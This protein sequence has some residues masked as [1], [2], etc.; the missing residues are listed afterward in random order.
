[1]KL[2]EPKVYLIGRTE[3]QHDD[4]DRW[5][6][7]LHA[8][9]FIPA[10]A[11]GPGAGLIS[12]AAKRCYMSFQPFLNPNVKKVRDDIE[13][14]L[15]NILDSGHGCYDSETE[16]LTYEGWKK[17]PDVTMEDHF[18]TM[19]HDRKI[20]Y[21]KPV[22]LVQYPYK[23]KMYRVE[24]KY[25]DLLV[26]PNHKMYV[27]KTSTLQG[28]KRN[29]EDYA[30]I[31]AEEL[32]Q[33]LH[34]YLKV[35]DWD[36]Q[37]KIHQSWL[38]LLGFA[39]GDGY[40]RRGNVVEFTLSKERKITWL[41][42]RARSLGWNLTERFNESNGEFQ[43]NLHIPSEYI[44]SFTLIY[45]E[46]R[47]KVIPQDLI[48]SHSRE[49][50]FYLW[51]GLLQS[52]GHVDKKGR[53]SFFTTSKTL[54]D[55][56]Q[57][58]CLHLGISSS[59]NMT[60]SKENMQW[61]S[62]KPLYTI[63][64]IREYVKPQVNVYKDKEG[65]SRTY[66]VDDWEGEVFCAEM[67]G[68]SSNHTLFVRRNGKPVWSC[69]SVLEHVVYNFAIEN[70]SRVL[71]AELNRH[72]AGMAISEGSLRYIRFDDIAFW[73]PEMIEDKPDDDFDTYLK[74]RKTRETF[75]RVFKFVED[76]YK[77]M[78]DLWDIDNMPNFHEK[79]LLTSMFR[80]IVPMGCATGGV[81]SGNIRALRHIF[82]MRTDPAAEEEIRIVAAK[83]LQIM[84]QQEPLLFKDFHF[85]EEKQAWTCK[86]RKV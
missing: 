43:F 50:L 22:R 77:I 86:F 3:M 60:D 62:K 75:L 54:A 56:I 12:M 15:D 5:L 16:V 55:Q 32:G 6:T 31:S 76:N 49:G 85:D 14:Y 41:K 53:E 72:R 58:L 24:G 39:I 48:F 42:N 73:M 80:R 33:S 25:L 17:W 82:T 74:K 65:H 28:K 9:D 8:D 35:G 40:Y 59:L 34:A 11:H 23:G 47:E 29:V 13:K 46:D 2:V 18:C 69:N 70:V 21:L 30:A 61:Q 37:D 38:S 79:K 10:R 66:W 26:T 83:M 7:S 78:E 36:V 45:S 71:T 19:N 27:V 52:D 44:E 51:E 57:H 67:P 64:T 84:I 4:I 63:Q 81:W 68:D 1:M 20:V